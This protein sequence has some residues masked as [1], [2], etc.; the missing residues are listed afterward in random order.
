M[1]VKQAGS[2]LLDCGFSCVWNSNFAASGSIW[3]G[4]SLFRPQ[5]SSLCSGVAR[6][7]LIFLWF[8]RAVSEPYLRWHVV[9]C[10]GCSL[11]DALAPNRQIYADFGDWPSPFTGGDV[12][13]RPLPPAVPK[14]VLPTAPPFDSAPQRGPTT[15]NSRFIPAET[16]KGPLPFLPRAINTLECW[17]PEVLLKIAVDREGRTVVGEYDDAK[18]AA[19]RKERFLWVLFWWWVA[20]LVKSPINAINN[21]SLNYARRM[22]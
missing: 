12:R 9:H 4:S 16:T 11:P 3:S 21:I 1:R 20:H 22:L 18:S 10:I 5:E 19:L 15:S 14:P 13:G 7:C 8:L 6:S 2:K 17:S